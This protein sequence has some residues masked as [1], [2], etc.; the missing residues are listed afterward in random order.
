MEEY[1]KSWINDKMIYSLSYSQAVNNV[2]YTYEK[3]KIF[4]LEEDYELIIIIIT[5][6]FQDYWNDTIYWIETFN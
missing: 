6:F 4:F 1:E 5:L 2:F 3:R